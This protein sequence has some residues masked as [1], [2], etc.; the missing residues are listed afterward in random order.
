MKRMLVVISVF[1]SLLVSCSIFNPHQ[2]AKVII[3]SGQSNATGNAWNMYLSQEE[4]QK[5][6]R[7]FDNIFINAWNSLTE[8]NT[9]YF[10]PVTFGWGENKHTFGPELGLSDILSKEFGHEKFYI[11]KY[12]YSGAG[13]SEGPFN[14]NTP[15]SAFSELLSHMDASLNKLK[16]MNIEPEIVAFC[17]MQGESDAL[18]LSYAEEYYDKEKAFVDIIR[19]RYSSSSIDGGMYFIDGGINEEEN[20][21][22][23]Y[24]EIVN[25]AKKRLAEEIERNIYLDTNSLGLT[26]MNEPIHNPDIFHYDSSSEIKLGHAFGEVITNILKTI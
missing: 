25:G 6:T 12:T 22:W 11:I 3:I 8:N 14:P 5:Y 19:Q 15:G 13:L 7:G 9:E 21:V 20:T 17:W 26:S 10:T 2:K 4:Q 18:S 1:L 16:Q 23:T 24:Y